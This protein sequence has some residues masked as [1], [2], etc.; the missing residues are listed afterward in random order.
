MGTEQ[1]EEADS[2]Q[3]CR[4][5]KRPFVGPPFLPASVGLRRV[6]WCGDALGGFVVSGGCV[7]RVCPTHPS[8]LLHPSLTLAPWEELGKVRG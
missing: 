6:G 2:L 1:L 3:P 5:D 4:V 7:S 8:P